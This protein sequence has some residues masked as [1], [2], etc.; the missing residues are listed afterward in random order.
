M[1]TDCGAECG[2]DGLKVPQP[3]V[4]RIG[5]FKNKVFRIFKVLNRNFALK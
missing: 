2:V 1:K 3:M 4:W 5:W